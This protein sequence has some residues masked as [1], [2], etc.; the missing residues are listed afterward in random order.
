[1]RAGTIF[2]QSGAFHTGKTFM[3]NTWLTLRIRDVL[4]KNVKHW[5]A[6]P[7]I[8]MFVPD[9]QS[10]PGIVPL[11]LLPEKSANHI[12][13][14]RKFVSIAVY[15]TRSVSLMQSLLNKREYGN[16]KINYR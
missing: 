15:V 4:P 16:Y 8:P 6:T 2:S 9:V 11:R 5:H 1:M 13:S 7:L 12:S 14:T 3:M 10:V